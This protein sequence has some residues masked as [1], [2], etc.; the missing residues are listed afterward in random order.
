MHPQRLDQRAVT[1]KLRRMSP[2]GLKCL[3]TLARVGF[4]PV[5]H[6]PVPRFAQTTTPTRKST[7]RRSLR[8]T[9]YSREPHALPRLRKNLLGISIRKVQKIFPTPN[10]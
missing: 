4:L 5:F 7:E 2:C 6:L 8:K 3:L 10:L 9:S 1:P